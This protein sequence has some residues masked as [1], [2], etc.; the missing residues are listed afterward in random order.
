MCRLGKAGSAREKR[1]NSSPVT[2]SWV[3]KNLLN[4]NPNS[5]VNSNNNPQFNQNPHNNSRNPLSSSSSSVQ[6]FQSSLSHRTHP[7]LHTQGDEHHPAPQL[8][9]PNLGEGDTLLH[10]RYYQDK[11]VP[12]FIVPNDD[13]KKGCTKRCET[14]CNIEHSP[15]DLYHHSHNPNEKLEKF[16][17]PPEQSVHHK[18]K[19]SPVQRVQYKGKGS[20]AGV[21]IGSVRNNRSLHQSSS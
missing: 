6:Q 19:G 20:D 21:P 5:N 1:S 11:G 8:N 18:G 10:H 3:P 13:K 9:S 15:A 14:H 17:K 2:L 7:P 4:S 12:S 16:D